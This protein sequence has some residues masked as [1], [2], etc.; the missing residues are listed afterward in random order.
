MI[1]LECQFGQND[2]CYLTFIFKLSL[3]TCQKYHKMRPTSHAQ[4]DAESTSDQLTMV[5][6]G[7]LIMALIA[8][9]SLGFL[10]PPP[11]S[12]WRAMM[13]LHVHAPETTASA[14]ATT[15]A[16]S[17]GLEE[18]AEALGGM[19]RARLAWDC[20]CI[21]V[22]PQLYYAA[23]PDPDIQRLLPSCR[24]TQPLGKESLQRLSS[25]YTAGRIE[26]GVASLSH[27][28][29]SDADLTTKL[30]LKL[31]DGMEVETVIIPWNGVRS[32][33]CIS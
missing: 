9:C 13:P 29:T 19:G 22:D 12:R 20:Y 23:E 5:Q 7:V 1:F 6:C 24:R 33:L 3:I 18:L 31:A 15:G 26:G 28:S 4:H 16:L 25:L 10:Q 17:M 11:T 14:E 8:P 21:G 2:L 30:L 32:T 27:I